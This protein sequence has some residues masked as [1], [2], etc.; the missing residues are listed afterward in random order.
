[1]G[2]THLAH[3]RKRT[4]VKAKVVIKIKMGNAAPIKQTY[5]KAAYVENKFIKE[6]IDRLLEQGLIEEISSPWASP[7]VV[8]PKKNGKL[9]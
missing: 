8:V 9:I 4:N 5:Y 1:M 6:E 3:G 7:V 2:W